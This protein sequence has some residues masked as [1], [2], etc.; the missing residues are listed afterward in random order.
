MSLSY[1][2]AGSL[3]TSSNI[4][5][6]SG[7]SPGDLILLFV[8]V[9]PDTATI[10]TPAGYTIATTV[11]GGTGSTGPDTG[12]MK[13]AIY[14][15]TAT[16]NIYDEPTITITGSNVFETQTVTYSGTSGGYQ[17]DATGAVDTTTGSSFTATM[18][19]VI[20]I[21][22]G[23][24]VWALGIDPTDA[25]AYSNE[26][27][28]ATGITTT[29]LTELVEW[30]TPIANDMG[31]FIAGALYGGSGPATGVATISASA[32]PTNSN[33]AGPILLV[34]ARDVSPVIS[35]S[36]SDTSGVSIAETSSV[37]A[38]PPI[39]LL[40]NGGFETVGNWTV[41]DPAYS[42]LTYVTTPI[43]TNSTQKAK[44][45]LTSSG[46]VKTLGIDFNNIPIEP[47][48]QYTISGYFYNET[49]TLGDKNI[50]VDWRTGT[51]AQAKP[52][53]NAAGTSVEN[54]WERVSATAT[55]P[56][57]AKYAN[58]R[59][60]GSSSVIGSI[61]FDNVQ[62][63]KSAAASPYTDSINPVPVV[64]SDTAS[65]AISETSS[66]V[67]TTVIVASDTSSV[68]ASD[69]AS[70]SV[71]FTRTDTSSIS[72]TE[73]SAPFANSLGND[74]SSVSITEIRAIAGSFSRSD[75]GSLG[76]SETALVQSLLV[77][78]TGTEDR[79]VSITD[80]SNTV[81]LM[82]TSDTSSVKI[83]DISN[84]YSNIASNMLLNPTAETDTSN[85]TVTG[86]ATI[87]SVVSSTPQG[88]KAFQIGTTGPSNG[89]AT[90]TTS[91]FMWIPPNTTYTI[92]AI[93][94]WLNLSGALVDNQVR[95]DV[96]EYNADGSSQTA[97]RN[98][99]FPINTT[100]W[101]RI[102]TTFTTASNTAKVKLK[103]GSVFS[104]KAVDSMLFDALHL[105]TTGIYSNTFYP[106]GAYDAPALSISE[107][108]AGV[109][110]QTATDAAAVSVT[111][112]SSPSISS[113]GSETGAVSIT[114]TRNIAVTVSTTDTSSASVSEATAT[115]N[116]IPTADTSVMFISENKSPLVSFSAQDTSSVFVAETSAIF[117]PL[118]AI[119][120]TS[121]AAVESTS[122]MGITLS[123][124][125]SDT[126]TTSMAEVSASGGSANAYSSEGTDVTIS[127]VSA[128][129]KMISASDTSSMSYVEN[130]LNSAVINGLDTG[131]VSTSDASNVNK[132]QS[133]NATDSSAVSMVES[134]GLYVD[135]VFSTSDTSSVQATESRNVSTVKPGFDAFSISVTETTLVSKFSATTDVS[136]VAASESA[137]M[138]LS[139]AASD[140]SAI[141]ITDTSA[142]AFTKVGSDSSLVSSSETSNV[143]KINQPKLF[144][145]HN[146]VFVPGVVRYYNNGMWYAVS[147]KVVVSGI[148]V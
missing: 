47:N 89:S 51:G 132:T 123:K 31:G 40:P 147:F 90:A 5:T 60:F 49:A 41:T 1:A 17:V 122:P 117:N 3:A 12:P 102:T 143:N 111:E 142:V 32:T 148:L 138:L 61:Y 115:T 137:T 57:G 9:K 26:S 44:V 131:S 65:T 43:S 54:Q 130:I 125:G 95:I 72:I 80:V 19:V 121:V 20:D 24:A 110:G 98:T 119:E 86:A 73:S 30:D 23:D 127:D 29:T 79:T 52:S 100:D 144:A 145:Y 7:T 101:E 85:W 62:I 8:A 27:I 81:V 91:E 141:I 77:P 87:A 18:P 124:S 33:V 113:P 135:K 118:S 140:S 14:Y 35:K 88:S 114:E 38:T 93:A 107:S 74:A 42:T 34:R 108:T 116:I 82:S 56:S 37:F 25:S 50:F 104:V 94:K 58:I 10:T 11:S 71:S 92:S 66:I 48:T 70:T 53:L 6:Y 68:R 109:V 120:F 22:A 15:R 133:V 136:A 4:V 146:G 106:A 59:L 63:E 69:V 84:P 28:S 78:K 134:S 55:S 46:T 16:G 75:T 129:L 139:R 128:I 67:K 45:T 97:A 21:D 36:A 126:L 39:N 112:S 83:A 105:G 99:Y 76:I 64:S 13:G 2:G 96:L 103:I